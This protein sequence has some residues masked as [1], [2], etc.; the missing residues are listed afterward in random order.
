MLWKSLTLLAL[1]SLVAAPAAAQRAQLATS[2]WIEEAAP[3]EGVR[4]LA[5]KE[6]VLKQ[7]L[8][9]SGL[10]KL[11][12]SVA[13]AETGF[14]LAAEAELIEVSGGAGPIF[15]DG[16]L[17]TVKFVGTSPQGCFVD[18]NGDGL[19]DAAFR[20]MS[21]TPAFVTINGKMPKKLRPL[22]TP[23]PYQRVDPATSTLGAFIAIERRNYFNIYGL[24][25]FMIAFGSG[26]QMERIT[27]PIGFKSSQ[28]PKQM[29]I[30]GSSF[31][32]LK[33]ENGRLAV[34][35]DAAMPRQPFGVMKTITFR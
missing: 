14:D 7:R 26:D 3:P 33:E 12:R 10:A 34:R 25:N 2:W 13:D 35:V 15:C 8:L 17:K 11:T 9:P 23:I 21:Q 24:E 16:R 31:T 5:S 1:G 19:F 29:S 18:Q 6:P 30:L 32:A 20:M 27:D 22:A 4:F 28:L